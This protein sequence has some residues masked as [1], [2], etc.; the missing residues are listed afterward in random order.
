M[1]VRHHLTRVVRGE[2]LTSAQ[3]QA[4]IDE[5]MSGG[6]DPVAAG[7]L[8][9]A[10]ATRG[11]TLDE[12]TG[13]A[14]AMRAAAQPFPTTL[15][16]PVIDTCGTGGDGAGTFNISTAAAFVVAAAGVKVAKHGNRAVSSKSGSADVLVALGA[17]I[18]L[19]PA[20][21]ARVFEEVGFAFLFAPIYHP[22][23]RHAMPIRH[24]LGTRTVFNLLGPISNP[25]GVSRQVIGVFSPRWLLLADVLAELGCRRAMV[26]HGHDGLDEFS[27]AG[28]TTV[29][30]IAADG[31]IREFVVSPDDVGLEVCGVGDLVGGDAEANAG[32]LR[33]ILSGDAAEAGSPVARAVQFNAG[34][35][36]TV[37][38]EVAGLREGVEKAG[39]IVRSGAA[40]RTVDAFVA[41]TRDG[42]E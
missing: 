16:D 4:A 24:S 29:R 40:L 28:P 35:A 39:A 42:D 3:M 38:G 13:A 18:D 31:S 36:L 8:L 20:E 25:A 14:R 34:A 21:M 22:A 32:T 15:P 5:I 6:V 12:V 1:T 17:R 30:E 26:V 33:R 19:L 11:E 37:A 10:L 9:A 2:T 7:G 41:A 23:M 27:L